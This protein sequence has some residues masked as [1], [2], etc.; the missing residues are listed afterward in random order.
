MEESLKR[1]VRKLLKPDGDEALDSGLLLQLKLSMR[2]D[3]EAVTIVHDEITRNL[4]R[5]DPGMRKKCLLL[6]DFILRRSHKFR[7]AVIRRLNDFIKCVTKSDSSE[8]KQITMTLLDDWQEKYGKQYKTLRLACEFMR[9]QEDSL[10][11]TPSPIQIGKTTYYER[12]DDIISQSETLMTEC[13][14]VL[15]ILRG[16]PGTSSGKLV[17]T[18]DNMAL[19][20]TIRDNLLLFHKRLVP[21]LQRCLAGCEDDMNL[22]DTIAA[23]LSR[24]LDMQAECQTVGISA[25]DGDEFYVEV[26]H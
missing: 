6:T 24:I 14:N 11:G 10:H 3:D 12:P 20:A 22:T 2:H 19:F 4:N 8:L 7:E 16:S 17:E 18:A 1:L 25:Q 9:R 23:T 13:R 26:E 5:K 21:E 15:D